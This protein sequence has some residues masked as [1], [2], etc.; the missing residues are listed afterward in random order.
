M[1]NYLPWSAQA[2]SPVK[3]LRDWMRKVGWHEVSPWKWKRY[4]NAVVEAGPSTGEEF[5][6]PPTSQLEDACGVAQSH[7]TCAD[8]GNLDEVD[9]AAA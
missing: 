3:A 5:H 1:R 8:V 4:N 9:L 7:N 2:G 6:A